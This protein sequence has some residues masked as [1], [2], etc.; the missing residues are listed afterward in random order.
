MSVVPHFITVQSPH[1]QL[2]T[3]VPA[4]SFDFLN[5]LSLKPKEEKGKMRSDP[6]GFS[7]AERPQDQPLRGE[8]GT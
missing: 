2:D 1:F 5:D 8:A 3:S 4:F 6:S 7:P